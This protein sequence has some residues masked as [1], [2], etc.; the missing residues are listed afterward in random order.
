MAEPLHGFSDSQRSR[1][2]R[3]FV[4]LILTQPESQVQPN[5]LKLGCA[6]DQLA[7]STTRPWRLKTRLPGSIKSYSLEQYIIDANIRP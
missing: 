1:R 6:A 7:S 3:R 2:N 4:F 5:R